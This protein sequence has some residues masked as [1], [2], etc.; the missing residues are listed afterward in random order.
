MLVLH[1]SKFA[2]CNI[3]ASDLYFILKSQSLMIINY[4][5]LTGVE[6][7]GTAESLTFFS[8]FSVQWLYRQAHLYKFIISNHPRVGFAFRTN[9]S[10][11]TDYLHLLS[12]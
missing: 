8:I 1:A 3:Y 9:S 2:V 10:V 11:M 6:F 7:A 4:T 12:L 5:L